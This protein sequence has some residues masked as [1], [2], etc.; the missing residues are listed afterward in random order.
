LRTADFRR[1]RRL[2]KGDHIVTWP[3]PVKPTWM[4]DETYRRM[5]K[6]IA[7]REV[8][9]RVK[10]PGF[11]VASLVVVTSLTDAATYTKEDIAELYH[12]RW[13]AELTG[14]VGWPC[15]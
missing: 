8:Q 3:R 11:R 13:L 2:G 14:R 10:Q 1:G 4:D 5:P 7:V 12:K 15:D 9:V 6:S